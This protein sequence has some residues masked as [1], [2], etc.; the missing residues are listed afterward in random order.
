MWAPQAPHT[1]HQLAS[2]A[3]IT[4]WFELDGFLVIPSFDS[5]QP[6][7]A[8]YFGD[9]GVT[10]PLLLQAACGCATRPQVVRQAMNKRPVRACMPPDQVVC[11]PDPFVMCAKALTRTSGVLVA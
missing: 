9:L 7:I 3:Q 4:H 10:L 5:W 1:P 2:A 6:D 11:T 8:M